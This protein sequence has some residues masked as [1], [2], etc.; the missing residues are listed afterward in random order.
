MDKRLRYHEHYARTAK[1]GLRGIM[2]L[3]RLRGLRPKTIRRL[4]V[5][6]VAPVVDYASF[7]WAARPTVSQTKLLEPIQRL[8]TQAITGIFK[9]AALAIAQA[10]A[11]ITPLASRWHRAAMRTWISWHTLPIKH[12]FGKARQRVDLR[13]RRYISP[14]QRYAQQCQAVEGKQIETIDPYTTAPWDD[15]IQVYIDPDHSSA[16][17]HAENSSSDEQ[18]E[19]FFTDGSE[20]NGLIGIGVA[21]RNFSFHQ[22]IGRATDLNVY[23]AE[24]FAIYQAIMNIESHVIQH[25][26]S[27]TK[28]FIVFSDSQ[29]ALQ[30]LIRPQQRSGQHLIRAIWHQA[31]RPQNNYYLTTQLQWVPAHYGIELN[32]KANEEARRAT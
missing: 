27:R 20:C 24:L 8:A 14:L 29:A 15:A 26:E 3:K 32:E 11:S 18:V 28:M 25:P 5:S 21:H 17:D 7:V 19:A 9:T 1:R 10:E 12:P 23:F 30:A 31:T 13:N 2:A 6:T 16:A 4:W 22:T